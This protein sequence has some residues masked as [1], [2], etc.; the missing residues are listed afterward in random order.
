[1]MAAAQA[2]A[3][4]HKLSGFAGF[5]L[6]SLFLIGLAAVGLT[7]LFSGEGDAQ[8][9]WTSAVVAWATQLAAFPVVRRLTAT[10]LVA[11]WGFGSLVRFGTLLVYALLGAFVLKLSIT[12]ALVSLALFYFVSMV[13]EP[14]FLRS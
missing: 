12:A 4:R 5:A 2:T 9:I 6:A 11:G 8:A 3:S 13:I 7:L 10:N 14:L 1:M